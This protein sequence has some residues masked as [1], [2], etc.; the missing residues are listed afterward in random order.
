VRADVP[1]QPN[2]CD[3][4]LF[5]AEFARRFCLTVPTIPIFSPQPRL[6]FPYFLRRDWFKPHEAGL[7][8]RRH[9]HKSVLGLAGQMVER[10]RARERQRR[11]RSSWVCMRLA[12]SPSPPSARGGW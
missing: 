8:K 12:F 4:G 6:G 1:Q 10:A 3:C 7:S 9:I 5:L 2:S 11:R